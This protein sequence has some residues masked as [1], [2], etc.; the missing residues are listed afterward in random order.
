MLSN[1]IEIT[2]DKYDD[3]I[4]LNGFSVQI[5]YPGRTIY[6]SKE[7]LETSIRITQSFRDYAI[8]IIGI[9]E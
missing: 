8:K 3:A 5:R 2:E 6:L 4:L 9:K 1:K 7:E